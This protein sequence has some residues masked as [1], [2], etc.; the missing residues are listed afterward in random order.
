M[1]NES[2]EKR[3]KMKEETK[4]G[5]SLKNFESSGND[6]VGGGMGLSQFDPR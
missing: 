4:R 6:V 2:L 3:D 1:E 5:E